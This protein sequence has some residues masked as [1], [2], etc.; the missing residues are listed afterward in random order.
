MEASCLI[1]RLRR[2]RILWRLMFS[3]N[4]YQSNHNIYVFPPF[5]LVGPLLC[6]LF[7]QGQRFAFTVID[8]RLHLHCYW[9]AILHVIVVDSF[10]LRWKGDLAAL[11]FAS[12]TS[13][14]FVAVTYS[15]DTGQRYTFVSH[16][17]ERCNKQ[18]GFSI[19]HG[20]RMDH[21]IQ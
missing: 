14:G 21:K 20:V 2:P 9:W 4:Q 7:N 15:A 18:H 17:H 6:Y 19:L 8:H 10:L 3:L 12:H 1:T 16:A 13:L 5:I 11:L